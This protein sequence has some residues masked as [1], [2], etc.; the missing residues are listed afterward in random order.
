MSTVVLQSMTELACRI[1]H[2]PGTCCHDQHVA[3]SDLFKLKDQKF[4]QSGH[5]PLVWLSS[6]RLAVARCPSD[7]FH[8]VVQ[9]LVLRSAQ[10]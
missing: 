6:I 4:N 8:M 2:D 9:L 3:R 1:L 10:L 5:H 7:M